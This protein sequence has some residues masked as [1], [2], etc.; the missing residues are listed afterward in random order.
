MGRLSRGA[1][2]DRGAAA[3]EFALVVPVLL[4]LVFGMIDY[5]LFF[6]DSLGARDGAR[7]AGRQASVANFS[8]SGGG[9]CPSGYSSSGDADLQKIACRAVDQ[10]GPIG[11]N[12][13]AKV[14]APPAGWDVGKDVLVCV[15]VKE[16]G[17]TGFT[18]MPNDATVRA[19][20]R[21][22]IEQ[23][24][25][26]PDPSGTAEAHRSTAPPPADIFGEL[27]TEPWCA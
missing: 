24:P 27:D 7:A 13:Y 21:M 15:A 11:G 26:G 3:L 14:L 17:V 8:A 23:N 16:N 2:A 5:G 18:P 10:T 6:S 20:I 9:T 4:T 19:K 1:A 12:A 22:R 25:A